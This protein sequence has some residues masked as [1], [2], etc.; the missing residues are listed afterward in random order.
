MVS[1]IKF[2]IISFIY[3]Y[4]PLYYLTTI[5]YYQT[6]PLYYQTTILYIPKPLLHILFLSF[7]YS[8]ILAMDKTAKLLFGLFCRLQN[9]LKKFD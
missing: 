6:T 1:L 2:L 8:T 9:F 5:L 7:P 3:Q 4:T